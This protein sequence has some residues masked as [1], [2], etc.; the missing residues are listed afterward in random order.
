MSHDWRVGILSS[1]GDISS[2]QA[3]GAPPSVVAAGAAAGESGVALTYV[4]FAGGAHFTANL[5]Q[6]V[7]TFVSSGPITCRLAGKTLEHD[8]VDGSLSVLPAGLDTGADCDRDADS[9]MIAVDP[10]HL[11]LAAAEDS[12]LAARLIERLVGRDEGLLH[13]ARLLA[14][15]C[16]RGYVRGSLFWNE[17]AS[18][19]VAGLVARHTSGR[20]PGGGLL[21]AAVL[22]RLRDYLMAHLDEPIDVATLARMT[23]RSQFHFSRVFRRTVGVSPYRYVIHLRLGRAVELVRQREAGL[24]E[25]AAQTGFADQSHL[26]RWVRRVY[27]VT[28]TQLIP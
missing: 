26:S 14:S 9:L 3:D 4:R 18:R 19:F 8:A 10:S 23:G 28:P 1:V 5:R 25:I 22:G 2:A 7:I 24:A 12:A 13:L 16:A 20:K 21:D 6:H 15:E 17:T 11:A 27:G